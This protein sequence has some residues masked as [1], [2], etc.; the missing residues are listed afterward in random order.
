MPTSSLNGTRAAAWLTRA[1]RRVR[2]FGTAMA[3]YAVTDERYPPIYFVRM[4]SLG[5]AVDLDNYNPPNTPAPEAHLPSMLLIE[6][7]STTGILEVT[8]IAGVVS[9]IA[10][11][12][13]G[14]HQLR[15]AA[16]KI[17]G[18]TTANI[19]GVTVCWNQKG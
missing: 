1:G 6:T 7:L 19:A 5:A 9:A 3:K 17:G 10:F 16:S 14:L 2:L 15:L 12:V 13:A 11:P 18:G 8:D 4:T